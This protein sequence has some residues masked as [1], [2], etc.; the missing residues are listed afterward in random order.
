MITSSLS[1][2]QFK[3]RF[4][5]FITL[6]RTKPYFFSYK[7]W[8]S[9]L[10]GNRSG[11]HALVGINWYSNWSVEKLKLITIFTFLLDWV[12]ISQNLPHFFYL[13]V[14][15]KNL[16]LISP[17]IVKSN[18]KFLWN[19]KFLKSMFNPKLLELIQTGVDSSICLLN[20]FELI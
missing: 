7:R 6:P 19:P 15:I 3:K 5:P 1:L 10:Q 2:S 8:S 9:A 18:T 17:K 12:E 14:K 16:T 20:L 11:H 4:C 13:I